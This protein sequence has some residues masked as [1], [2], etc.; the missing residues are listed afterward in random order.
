MNWAALFHFPETAPQATQLAGELGLA[1]HE[2]AVHR[3]PDGESLV[4][5]EPS[6]PTAL[7]YRSLDNPNTKL[8][9]LLL[10]ASALRQNGALRVILIAPYLAYMRQ[11]AAF[12]TGEA[13]SQRVIG[14]LLADRFDILLTVDPHLHRTHSMAEIVPG[15]GAVS[16]AAAPVLSRAI[17]VSD[18]PLLVAPDAEARQ[19]AEAVASSRHLE[20]IVAEKRRDGDRQVAVRFPDVERVAGRSVVLIDDLISSGQ[21]I[22]EAAQCLREAGATRIEALATHC[23]AA[24]RDL[25]RLRAAGIARVRATDT[26]PGP[27]AVIPIA[28]LIA[29]EICR[30]GWLQG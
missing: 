22:A 20:V 15:I 1:H 9:E 18:L 23:L 10:A 16:I 12:H 24:P 7:L 14:R 3:F 4:R 29:E 26:V 21:T 25:E 13:V 8:V 6:P 17:D 27:A 28:P 2:I 19:W 11:D 30:R 5:V